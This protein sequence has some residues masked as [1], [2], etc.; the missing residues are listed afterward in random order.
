[1]NTITLTEAEAVAVGDLLRAVRDDQLGAAKT[2]ELEPATV[3]RLVGLFR[4]KWCNWLMFLADA[5][6]RGIS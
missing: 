4:L 2:L 3:R 1:M 6:N 5:R